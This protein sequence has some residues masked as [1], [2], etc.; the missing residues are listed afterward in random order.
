M[1][2]RIRIEPV[3]C[4]NDQIALGVLHALHAH[5]RRVPDEIS[6][7]GFD[8]TPESSQYWPPLTTVHQDFASVG[9]RAFALLFEAMQGG[10]VAPGL[11]LINNELVVRGSTA[12]YRAR[13]AAAPPA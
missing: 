3:F 10:E 1:A 9:E 5:G 7:V 12:R 8:D 13:A 4:A 2:S 6:V 11:R